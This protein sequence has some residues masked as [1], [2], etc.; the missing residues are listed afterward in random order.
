MVRAWYMDTKDT[1]QRLEHH[2]NP[3]SFLTLPELLERTGVEHY[4][5]SNNQTKKKHLI[6]ITNKCKTNVGYSKY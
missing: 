5:V 3:P 6:V 1:D 2:R 4:E